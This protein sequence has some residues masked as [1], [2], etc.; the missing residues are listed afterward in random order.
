M[1]LP[2][3]V[4]AS[5]ALSALPALSQ[6]SA[7]YS[8]APDLLLTIPQ[9][10][11]HVHGG[12]LSAKGEFIGIEGSD[13]SVLTFALPSAPRALSRLCIVGSS[14][15]N[16]TSPSELAVE[17]LDAPA[18][19]PANG[20]VSAAESCAL[21]LAVARGDAPAGVAWRVITRAPAQYFSC[22]GKGG[23]LG[24]AL[25]VSLESAPRAIA[26]RVSLRGFFA[27]EKEVAGNLDT[28]PKKRH[29]LTNISIF[30][31]ASPAAPG[32]AAAVA[33]T[34]NALADAAGPEA[35]RE[36]SC[37][38]VGAAAPA[39][40]A[41]CSIITSTG[42]A[43]AISHLLSALSSAGAAILP[44]VVACAVEALAGVLL[45]GR[46]VL[47]AETWRLVRWGSLGRC[48]S[49]SDGD[50]SAPHG[51]TARLERGAQPAGAR[52]IAF[53]DVALGRLGGGDT[54]AS[55]RIFISLDDKIKSSSKPDEPFDFFQ[56]WPNAPVFYG[57]WE[58]VPMSVGVVFPRA[59]RLGIVHI[60]FDV[61]IFSGVQGYGSSPLTVIFSTPAA[62]G[63][64]APTE[65]MLRM[66]IGPFKIGE[67]VR[68]KVTR[69][70][71]FTAYPIFKSKGSSVWKSDG[72]RIWL[73]RAD[74]ALLDARPRLIPFL[75]FQKSDR[76]ENVCIAL[77][78]ASMRTR[79]VGDDL[80][81][82]RPRALAPAHLG[83]PLVL[84]HLAD[85]LQSLVPSNWMGASAAALRRDL[86][87]SATTSVH[88]A[89]C[90]AGT[91]S[92]SFVDDGG[93][94]SV[95]ARGRP[96]FLV[97]NRRVT[98]AVERAALMHVG[99][100]DASLQV[101]RSLP[102]LTPTTDVDSTMRSDKLHI[103]DSFLPENA[104]KADLDP[105]MVPPEFLS[106]P[107]R[108]ING[109]SIMCAAS[110]DN[111]LQALRG[112]CTLIAETAWTPVVS[113]ALA[114]D[115]SPR[116]LLL[117]PM[118]HTAAAGGTTAQTFLWKGRTVR[119]RSTYE[120]LDSARAAAD[121]LGTE[122]LSV[123]FDISRNK[124]L[125]LSLETENGG[126]LE[127]TPSRPAPG[128]SV[129]VI[130]ALLIDPCLVE[131]PWSAREAHTPSDTAGVS[132]T[133]E[134]AAAETAANDT[135]AVQA[136]PSPE[137]VGVS[138]ARAIELILHPLSCSALDTIDALRL[139]PLLSVALPTCAP[140]FA[141]ESAAI[142]MLNQLLAVSTGAARV[143]ALNFA[144]ACLQWASLACSSSGGGC[145][146]STT[147]T[148]T[149]VDENARLTLVRECVRL[150]Q[151]ADATERLAAIRL[152]HNAADL[153]LPNLQ[154][155]AHALLDAVDGSGG[156]C[157]VAA[158][159][160]FA[161][162][163]KGPTVADEA[164]RTDA[165]FPHQREG[166]VADDWELTEV[167][168]P[169][170]S[171]SVPSIQPTLVGGR[172]TPQNASICLVELASRRRWEFAT[173]SA[174]LPRAVLDFGSTPVGEGSST[175]P[176]LADAADVSAVFVAIPIA[177]LSSAAEEPAL[178]D[179]RAVFAF[180]PSDIVGAATGPLHT[181]LLSSFPSLERATAFFD[182]HV[183]AAAQLR[184]RAAQLDVFGLPFDSA[185]S[186]AATKRGDARAAAIAVALAAS[187]RAERVSEAADSLR[188]D[189][190]DEES[191]CTSL[192][193][194]ST[195]SGEGESDDNADS[196][197]ESGTSASSSSSSS[198]SSG[199]SDDDDDDENDDDDD[200]DGDN[201]IEVETEDD[202][203]DGDDDDDD[204]EG[205]MWGG[206]SYD[207]Y[208]D[209]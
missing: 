84:S 34:L 108:A 7:P 125:T 98:I 53:R 176:P 80:R 112:F 11:V 50:F 190:S 159:F 140:L 183:S 193:T 192:I 169:P 38:D 58:E 202:E 111:H 173:R 162:Y 97:R 194:L 22:L 117:T 148:S 77:V 86:V 161:E 10:S 153:L 75:H 13:A 87:R 57:D 95:R 146:G 191:D 115:E 120:T 9:P 110:V 126:P 154:A 4:D 8:L 71:V 177:E 33:P 182:S 78:R 144:T 73:L 32:T 14:G 152:L 26:V 184:E 156:G 208:D 196:E 79:D 118:L 91:D 67:R 187:L 180:S 136:H 12:R 133:V 2:S 41:L 60:S 31:R 36:C 55:A 157:I 40:L 56:K 35:V 160:R 1:S 43:R 100:N 119:V 47:A 94:L 69:K 128:D 49:I 44:R 181:Q 204:D 172:M 178:A 82:P 99:L 66:K 30:A 132:V 137:K 24:R 150:L 20:V 92:T 124:E 147:G 171:F 113:S 138:G 27:A 81:P 96:T 163:R 29:A 65:T 175:S 209:D 155:R 145:G 201:D 114:T 165:V 197:S 72:T 76:R 62:V 18:D 39:T 28:L 19:G 122:L 198:G 135:A 104:L 185:A 174:A 134:T 164:A 17:V 186:L 70:G 89:V 166:A 25:D 199:S 23:A 51:D 127:N 131:A 107:A 63:S 121:A 189:D 116:S 54:S 188:D 203:D 105:C 85:S 200:D 149:S 3:L 151:S 101:L 179:A 141:S 207:G 42:S 106:A 168:M 123:P 21:V 130:G 64:S 6:L 83:R 74:R 61:H 46:H 158:L 68:V 142:A 5:R 143:R 37:G 90:P 129:Y 103:L 15:K 16:S 205:D 170:S 93:L 102:P 48:S 109:A 52:F 195:D 206:G 45:K 59:F 167:A 139:R 88:G